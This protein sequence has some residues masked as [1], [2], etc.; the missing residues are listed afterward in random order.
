MG[1]HFSHVAGVVKTKSVAEC[2]EF[3]YVWKKSCH[4]AVW[5][6]SYRQTYGDCG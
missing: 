5:K 4:Y 3:Y 2:V 6:A 1:K